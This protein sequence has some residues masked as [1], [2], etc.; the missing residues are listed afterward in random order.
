[1]TSELVEPQK[2]SDVLR[3]RRQRVRRFRRS[4]RG[5]EGVFGAASGAKGCTKGFKAS[6]VDM[7]AINPRARPDRSHPPPNSGKFSTTT[8]KAL[9]VRCIGGIT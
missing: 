8:L 5:A 6:T 3:L 7:K 4:E 9:K 1:V 2:R